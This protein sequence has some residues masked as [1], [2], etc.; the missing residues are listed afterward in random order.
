MTIAVPVSGGRAPVTSTRRTK[1]AEAAAA[2]SRFAASAPVA[3]Q[4][5]T[6]QPMTSP[7]EPE[8]VRARRRARRQHRVLDRELLTMNRAGGDLLRRRRWPR[9]PLVRTRLTR[10]GKS[11][12]RLGWASGAG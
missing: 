4:P 2:F 11:E 7:I 1:A 5:G 9:G 8:D 3:T 10:A 6:W 12:G